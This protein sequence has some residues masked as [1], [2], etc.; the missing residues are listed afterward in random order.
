MHHP[1]RRKLNLLQILTFIFLFLT[2]AC[3][4]SEVRALLEKRLQ[5]DTTSTK[6][7]CVK[8]SDVIDIF[9]TL[10]HT[11]YTAGQYET[12]LAE[13]DP[14]HKKYIDRQVLCHLFQHYGVRLSKMESDHL[15]KFLC[16]NATDETHVPIASIVQQALQLYN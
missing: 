7:L 5:T 1:V 2:Y 6:A 3:R 4:S 8:I 11:N 15:S 12:L 14:Q 13:L 16:A 10:Q 9:N